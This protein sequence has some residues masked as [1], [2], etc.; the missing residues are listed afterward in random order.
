[1]KRE[2]SVRNKLNYALLL[3]ISILISHGW[4]EPKSTL[5]LKILSNG[6]FIP[7][8]HVN[9]VLIAWETYPKYKELD[10]LSQAKDNLDK[11]LANQE[12]ELQKTFTL[13]LGSIH[14]KHNIETTI[15]K[16]RIKDGTLRT[17]V[18]TGS[19]LVLGFISGALIV[20]LK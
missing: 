7:A 20:A 5:Q 14:N 18:F 17:I 9:S 12:A 6:I 8:I 1:M 10:K 16:K 4:T 11:V 3:A 2:S 13:T 19:A 15:F